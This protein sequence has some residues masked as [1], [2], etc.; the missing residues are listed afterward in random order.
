MNGTKQPPALTGP[1]LE[2]F[3]AAV[4]EAA[5]APLLERIAEMECQLSAVGAG[6]VE[7]LRK[8]AAQPARE[9]LHQIAEPA[10]DRDT[11]FYLAGWNG[12]RWNA[13]S[14]EHFRTALQAAPPAPAGVAVPQGEKVYAALPKVGPIGYASVVDVQSYA[15][16]MGIGTHLPGVR[17]V[18][19]WTSDQMRAFADA[20]A[21]LRATPAPVPEGVAVQQEPQLS[22][23]TLY[24]LRRLLSN[25][26]T[27][28]GPEFRAELTK[29]VD[30]AFRTQAPPSLAAAPAQA[31]AVPA[32]RLVVAASQA[33]CLLS[34]GLDLS[35]AEY[36]I[37]TE[38]AAAIGVAHDA[39]AAPAQEHATQLAGQGQEHRP[40]W[41]PFSVRTQ[42]AAR[43]GT[44]V[45]AAFNKLV[46]DVIE[47][48]IAT[49]AAAPVQAQE[50]ARD[51][52]DHDELR[53]I[54]RAVE[55][56]ADCGETDVDYAL[57]MRA[58]QAGYLECTHFQV[59]NESA[60]NLDAARAAQGGAA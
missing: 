3:R 26:H 47:T 21:A 43:H 18:A 5:R 49:H 6:G 38:L 37:V 11:H 57:L 59:M 45:T 46:R 48:Y 10:S 55:Q 32:E 15:K 35:D 7:P 20:T 39:T 12:A 33:Y 34:S 58:A 8:P 40:N 27:L 42:I 30:E 25:Q 50:D 9:C 51:A 60:L 17:D 28:T 14:H 52:L 36:G 4:A 44:K 19:L 29:I 56:F 31:V 22:A 24:L 53:E 1:D 54:Q 13:D 2:E 16:T 23:D 41:L